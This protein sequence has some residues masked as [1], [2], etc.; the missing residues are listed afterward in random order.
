MGA[1][2][3][4]MTEFTRRLWLHCRYVRLDARCLLGHGDCFV[5]HVGRVAVAFKA[6]CR[7]PPP[8][9][10]M[11]CHAM[12]CHATMLPL[13]R[14]CVSVCVR[15]CVLELG[16][17]HRLDKTTG[18]LTFAMRQLTSSTSSSKRATRSSQPS[19]LKKRPSPSATPTRTGAASSRLWPWATLPRKM[20][21]TR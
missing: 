15:V 1:P 8:T 6:K 16:T 19:G 12:P 4:T 10:Q 20:P 17:A 2:R 11:P 7:D 9:R 21:L 5:K 13:L 14:T 3:L 18:L